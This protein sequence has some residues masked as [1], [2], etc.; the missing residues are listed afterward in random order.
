[1]RN[2]RSISACDFV[3]EHS[4]AAGAHRRF[5]RGDADVRRALHQLQLVARL[6]QTQ[7]V[8]QMPQFEELMRRLRAHAHHGADAVDP[9]DQL[10]IEFGVA[11][12]VVIHAAATFEQARQDLVDVGDRIRI[13]H[14]EAI[15]RAV[16][17]AARAIPAFAVRIAFAAEQDRFAVLAP[18]TSTRTASGSGNPARYSRSESCR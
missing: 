18:G 4:G 12:E 7:L 17:P 1:M 14:A 5:M 10:E 6:E 13:V 8:E 9:A 15:D 2:T 3:F 11:A 16:G